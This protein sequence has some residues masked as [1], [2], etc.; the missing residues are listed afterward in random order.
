VGALIGLILA[1]CGVP[2]SIQ[3]IVAIVVSFAALFSVR[4]FAMRALNKRVKN[5]ATNLDSIIGRRLRLV[6]EITPDSTG[7]VR[8]NGVIWSAATDNTTETVKEGMWVCVTA[9]AGNRLIVKAD[10]KQD[11]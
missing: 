1:I 4:P 2:Y 11:A 3:I 10:E 5:S 9:I 8:L 6:T 7:T